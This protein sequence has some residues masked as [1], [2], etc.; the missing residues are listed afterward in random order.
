MKSQIH[1]FSFKKW[2]NSSPNPQPTPTPPHP[3]HPGQNGRHVAD[4]TFWCIFV[5]EKF[6]ILITMS[7]KFIPKGPIDNNPTFGLDNGLAPNRRKCIIWTN[8]DLTH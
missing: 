5:N 6:C 4:N 3:P 8:A 1:A 2:I 7:L